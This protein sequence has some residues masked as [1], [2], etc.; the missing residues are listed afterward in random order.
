MSRRYES[1][2]N[3]KRTNPYEYEQYENIKERHYYGKYMPSEKISSDYPET[4]AFSLGN[5]NVEEEKEKYEFED[6]DL[7]GRLQIKLAIKSLLIP[8][9]N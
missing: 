3:V 9:D 7:K 1:P 2:E 4:G 5:K 8:S 6:C